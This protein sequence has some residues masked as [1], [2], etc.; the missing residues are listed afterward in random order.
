[1]NAEPKNEISVSVQRE[2][3]TPTEYR[4]I[5]GS[6]EDIVYV[7]DQVQELMKRV[8]KDGIHYGCIPG[9]DKPTLL[10]PGAESLISLFQL[11]PTPHERI[12][13]LGN[14][15]PQYFIPLLL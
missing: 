2:I 7:H 11:A 15:H 3:V 14:G 10:K 9:T 6:I 13:E 12:T 5:T 4:M 8:M 1:M